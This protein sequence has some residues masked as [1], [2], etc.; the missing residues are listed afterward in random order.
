MDLPPELGVVGVKSL[1]ERIRTTPHLP[2]PLPV[3]AVVCE[4][5]AQAGHPELF[6]G[7]SESHVDLH[8]Q[9]D[10]GRKYS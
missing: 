3:L 4:E 10:R 5:R 7:P 2:L 6:T 8:K 1:R 9:K